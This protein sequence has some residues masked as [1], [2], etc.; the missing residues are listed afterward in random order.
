MVHFLLWMTI[1]IGNQRNV[2]R[3]LRKL[4]PWMQ[5]HDYPF[6]FITEAS[7]NLAEDDELLQLMGEAGFYAV[8]LGIETPDQDSLQVTRK[9]QNTRNPLVEACKQ[10]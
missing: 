4:I 1:F 10:N 2:K 8:F 6:T 3:F 9:L 5:Q 7:V